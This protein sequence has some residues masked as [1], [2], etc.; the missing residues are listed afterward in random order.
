MLEI[1]VL[2]F[3]L[4]SLYLAFKEPLVESGEGTIEMED[5]STP[6]ELPQDFDASVYE[7]L[8]MVEPE[9]LSKRPAENH[10]RESLEVL[11]TDGA[12]VEKTFIKNTPNLGNSVQ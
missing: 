7:P 8:P 10:P 9:Y 5:W 3:L 1:A 11:N 6:L 2:F 12:Y 4:C